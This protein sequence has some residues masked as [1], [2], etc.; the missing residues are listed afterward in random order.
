MEI[1]RKNKEGIYL[2]KTNTNII[3][4]TKRI[5]KSTNLFRDFANRCNACAIKILVVLTSFDEQMVSN[6]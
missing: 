5:N 6:V 2:K 3:V 4:K 1:A